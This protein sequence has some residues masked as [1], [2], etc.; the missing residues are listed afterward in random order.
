VTTH[1]QVAAV[2]DAGI[3][4]FNKRHAH[5]CDGVDTLI[6]RL[7]ELPDLVGAA[8]ELGWDTR[9]PTPWRRRGRVPGQSTRVGSGA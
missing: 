8:I 7:V 9:R 1:H 6:A 2:D 4:V 3:E 5:T